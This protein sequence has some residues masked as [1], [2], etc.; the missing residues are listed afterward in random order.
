MTFKEVGGTVFYVRDFGGP[1]SGNFGHAGIPGQV[2]GSASSG[3]GSTSKISN[4]IKSRVSNDYYSPEDFT[5]MGYTK[6]QADA[7]IFYKEEG[8]E[9]IRNAI[10]GRDK[11]PR[12]LNHL[13][14]LDSALDRSE[15][16][17]DATLYHG[18]GPAESKMFDK[19]E[20]GSG[21]AYNGFYSTSL[22]KSIGEKYADG[23]SVLVINAKKGSSGL[24]YKDPDN[25]NEVL[26]PRNKIYGV[27]KITTNGGMK[28]IHVRQ[29]DPSEV[30]K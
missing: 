18:M 24:Y 27:E 1:G 10:K 9:D 26:L 8:F 20:I 28:Y 6:S 3:G 7:I 2:G 13:K 17:E 4:S 25:E 11:S 15:L 29:V 30:K 14:E 22:D 16:A 12:V 5:S 23:K 19:I 21:F